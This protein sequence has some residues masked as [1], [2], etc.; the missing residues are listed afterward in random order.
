MLS[1]LDAAAYAPQRRVAR[2]SGLAAIVVTI[3]GILAASALSPTFSWQSS[4]LSDLGVTP[5]T[6]W[7]F[8]GA[9]VVGGIVGTPYA[10][11]LWS[12]AADPLSRLR[13]ATY[14]LA[15]ASMA[16]VGLVPAGRLLHLPLAVAFFTFAALTA[17]VD[18]VARLRLTSGKLALVAGVLAPTAW[19]V[20][21]LWLD[22]GG[23]AVPEFVAAAL[24][25]LWVAVL[26]PER[27]GRP[28]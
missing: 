26:S 7:L 19:P 6:A 10:W 21:L 11:A 14:L 1:R 23:I 12:A 15:L 13:G 16:G 2:L 20:W 25:G 18:G 17:V 3:G 4:A 9:L 8:N 22:G 28:A 5:A 27:P 24:F